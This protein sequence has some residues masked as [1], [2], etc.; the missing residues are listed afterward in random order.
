MPLY[1]YSALDK[2]WRRIVGTTNADS[3][4]QVS[5]MLHQRGLRTDSVGRV[6]LQKVS[7]ILSAVH[8]NPLVA[9]TV[10]SLPAVSLLVL[11]SRRRKRSAAARSRA[12]EGEPHDKK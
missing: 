2:S 12:T 5:A 11:A 8:S 10:I 3:A 7:K 6:R 4:D 1:Q 9:L